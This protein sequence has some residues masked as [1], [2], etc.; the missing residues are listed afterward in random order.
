MLVPEYV[1]N[2]FLNR[3]PPDQ[4]V[5]KQASSMLELTNSVNPIDEAMTASKVIKTGPGG[6]RSKDE[7]KPAHRNIHKSH[8]GNMAAVATPES[9]NVGI[10]THHTLN[11]LILNKY[12]SYG[13]KDPSMLTGWDTVGVSESLIP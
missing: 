2:K 11:P 13:L 1:I 12:G 9:N 3:N 6:L 10:I 5:E 8:I 7:F 4:S